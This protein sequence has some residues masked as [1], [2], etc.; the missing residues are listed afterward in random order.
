VY[1]SKPP[2]S[3]NAKKAQPSGWAFFMPVNKIT[4][5]KKGLVNK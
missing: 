3:S 5:N 2:A 1:A 4:G